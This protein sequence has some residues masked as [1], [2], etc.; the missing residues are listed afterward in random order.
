LFWCLHIAHSIA[1]AVNCP[2]TA[3]CRTHQSKTAAYLT[4]TEKCV[5]II[6]ALEARFLLIRL[7]EFGKW[8]CLGDTAQTA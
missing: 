7:A 2:D 4:E 1:Q 8:Q 6:G 5:I 3:V